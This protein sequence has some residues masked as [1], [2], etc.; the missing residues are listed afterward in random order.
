MS[1]SD[2]TASSITVQWEPVDC[3]HQN[4]DITGYLVLYSGEED[5]TGSL[6][7]SQDEVTITGLSSSTNYF[8]E[9]A[10]VNSVDTGNFSDSIITRTK[11]SVGKYAG[12]NIPIKLYCGCQNNKCLF[13]HYYCL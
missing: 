13:L 9:V 7:V 8:I 5:L 11:D 4:G 6:A 3:I 1:V 10:A 12:T 2:V